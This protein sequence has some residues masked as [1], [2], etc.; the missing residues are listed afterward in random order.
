M[1]ASGPSPRSSQWISTPSGLTS[2]GTTSIL[3][4][5]VRRLRGGARGRR[6]AGR[7]ARR[8]RRPER[9]G[10]G[11]GAGIGVGVE[12]KAASEVVAARGI[13][14]AREL[15]PGVARGD[16]GL[17][18]VG[19]VGGARPLGLEA[20]RLPDRVAEPLGEARR[21]LGRLRRRLR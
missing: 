18:G 7:G 15:E 3:A 2:A 19:G 4:G 17:V 10:R 20:R 12:E 9:A 11:G 6:R 14:R 16:Q 8:G 13:E 21:L 5:A 1:R